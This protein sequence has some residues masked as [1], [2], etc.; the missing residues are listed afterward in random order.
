MPPHCLKLKIGCVIVLL[1][2][3]DLKAELCNSTL[4]KVCALQ[5]NY[6]DAKVLTD[7]SSGERVFVFQIQLA[8]SVANLPFVLKRLQFPFRL[9]CSMTMNKSLGQTFDSVRVNLKKP[10]FS[11]GQLYVAYVACLRNRAFKSLFFK[12]DKHLN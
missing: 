12:I 7:V 9:A 10:C 5:N 2:N 6:S 4:M 1:R 11:H 3:L 8:P